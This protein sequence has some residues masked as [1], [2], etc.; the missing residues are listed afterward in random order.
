MLGEG[1]FI[2]TYMT[3]DELYGEILRHLAYDEEY[4]AKAVEI[5]A[6]KMHY[7]IKEFNEKNCQSY[8]NTTCIKQIWDYIE[9]Y[10]AND[11]KKKLR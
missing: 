1:M 10:I 4:Y 11:I 5:G 7:I 2:A 6:V 9:A 8:K 3:Y